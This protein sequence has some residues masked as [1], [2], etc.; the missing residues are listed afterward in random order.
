MALESTQPLV[1]ISTKKI[2]GGKGGRCVR[3]TTSPHSCAEWDCFTL[4]IFEEYSNIKFHENPSSDSRVVPFGRKDGQTEK[5]DEARG[6]FRP[7]Q[8]RQ[9]P[10]AVD[11]K[12]RLLIFQSY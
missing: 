7:R 1:K 12:G 10:R 11:L 3:L 5:H 6:V 4:P 9:L 2:P 8:T